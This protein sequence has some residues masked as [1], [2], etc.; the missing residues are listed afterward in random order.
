MTLLNPSYDIYENKKKPAQ[1]PEVPPSA[2]I[3]E[4]T[5][6]IT[7]RELENTNDQKK[8]PEEEKKE[9]DKEDR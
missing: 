6:R 4:K 9:E 1:I 5:D 7:A 3:L 8:S 2:E